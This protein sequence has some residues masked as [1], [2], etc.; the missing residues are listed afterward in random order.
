M[1][2]MSKALDPLAM[3]AT[4]V[5]AQPGVYALLLGSGVSTGAGIPTAWGVVREMVRRLAAA[6]DPDDPGAAERAAEDPEAWW[7]DNGDGQALGYSN[8]LAAMAP[9]GAARQALLASF[10]E[11]SE[12]DVAAGLKVPSAAHHAIADLAKHGYVRVIL[13]T[14]FD[15]LTEQALEAAGIPPQVVSRAEAV[16]GLTPLPHAPVTVMKLHG[17]YADLEMR[18]TIEEL[19]SYPDEWKALLGRV[20]D[21]YGLLISGWS[22]ASDKALVAAL[23]EVTVRRYPLYWDSRSSKGPEATRLLAQHRGVVVQT[24][25]ADELFGGLQARVDALERLAQPPLTT[26]MAIASLKRYL[27]DPTRRIDLHDL[28]TAAAERAADAIAAQPRTIDGLTYEVLQRVTAEHLAATE[29]L[30]RL[31]AAGVYYDRNREHTDLWVTTLQRLIVAR[32]RWTGGPVNSQLDQ[33]RHYPA[34]LLMRAAGLVAVSLGRDDVLL[35]LLRE[36]AWRSPNLSN[37]AVPAVEALHDYHVFEPEQL[38]SY[39]RWNGTRWHYP[40]S[41][42]L[43]EDLCEVVRYQIPDDGDYALANDNYEYR[44]ALVQYQLQHVAGAYGPA[45][46][47]FI[48]EN[49]W[50]WDGA[51]RPLAEVD[52]QAVADEADDRWPWWDVLGGQG[53]GG[54]PAIVAQVRELLRE[55]RRRW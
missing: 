30:L 43:R 36:P 24:T 4:A 7:Q 34:L 54:F 8:L 41:Q 39:P 23:E 22:A 48:G 52:F 15:R 14:N 11:P 25:S 27:H 28:A 55:T 12:E 33:L 2:T 45:P 50:E 26:A 20:F 53:P 29:P 44:V 18:N 49:H 17:D 1:V 32:G 19:N 10:F 35:R 21:E 38:L 13:T 51:R 46:G 40:V 9:T 37:Q 5:H 42:L 3:L 31:V 47:L 16:A 6:S